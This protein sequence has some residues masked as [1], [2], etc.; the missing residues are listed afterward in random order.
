M[1]THDGSSLDIE[2]IQQY[3]LQLE[4]KLTSLTVELEELLSNGMC[5]EGTAYV[6]GSSKAFASLGNQVSVSPEPIVVISAT[7]ECMP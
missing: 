5:E 6:A 1:S 3:S 7:I 4:I 2:C